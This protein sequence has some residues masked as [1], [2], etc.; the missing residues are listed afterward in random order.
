MS[1]T[2][3]RGLRRLAALGAVALVALAACGN[4]AAGSGGGSGGGSGNGNGGGNGATSVD[5]GTTRVDPT[6]VAT[7][8]DSIPLATLTEEEVAGLVWMREEEKLARDVYTTLG[9]QYDLRIFDNISGA[10]QTHMDSVLVLLE[11]YGIADPAAGK[12]VGDFTDPV[13]QGLYDQLVA[14]GSESLV[15]ALSV[16]AEIEELDI[17]DLRDRATETADIAL[18]YSNLERGSRNHLRAFTRQL[19]NNDATYTP[20]H[21]SQVDYDAIVSGDMEQG[22]GG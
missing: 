12:A 8:I 17:V 6:D 1:T 4:D 2:R 22:A 21:L 7:Q 20:T 19:A 18:V 9:E 14:A 3:V 13:L 15:A 11:R 10:E 5:D 16:G